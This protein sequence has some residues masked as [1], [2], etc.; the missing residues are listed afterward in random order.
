MRAGS[1]T[2]LCWA[3][4]NGTVLTSA[5]SQNDYDGQLF[6]YEGDE[7]GSEEVLTVLIL[8]WSAEMETLR[9]VGRGEQTL[10]GS[11]TDMRCVRN[12]HGA[13]LLFLLEIAANTKVN[14]TEKTA[15]GNW[16]VLGGTVQQLSSPEGVMK[17]MEVTDSTVLVLELCFCSSTSGLALGNQLGLVRVYNFSFISKEASLHIVTVTKKESQK[18][19]Q[20]EGPKCSACFPILDSSAQALQYVDDEAKLAVSYECGRVAVLDMHAFSV[21]FVYNGGH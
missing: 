11:F 20:G 9:C 2:A 5:K 12:N 14:K 6:V 8:K 21:S 19:P 17:D 16:P 15:K 13:D 3:S 4:S 18:Q 7:I 1:L 10:S